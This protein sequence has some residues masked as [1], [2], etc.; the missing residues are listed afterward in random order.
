MDLKS[1]ARV[2][3]RRD[4]VLRMGRFGGLSAP[5]PGPL[6]AVFALRDRWMR[7]RLNLAGW[8]G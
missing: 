8:R 1:V 2:Y 5:V 4:E 3:R 7:G 6:G